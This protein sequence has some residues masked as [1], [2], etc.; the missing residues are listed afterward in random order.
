MFSNPKTPWLGKIIFCLGSGP[1]LN[2]ISAEEWEGLG[3]A[4]ENYGS[5][6]LAVNSSI[7]KPRQFGLES[8][9]LFFTD[10]SWFW[11]NE[12]LVREFKGL[13]FTTSRRAKEDYLDLMRIDNRT[14]DE[15]EVGSGRLKDG[16]SSGHRAVSLSVMLGAKI[17]ILLGYDMRVIEGKSHFHNEYSNTE[18]EKEY[19]QGFVPS[20]DKWYE[21][22]LKVGCQILN[23]TPNSAVKEFPMINLEWILERLRR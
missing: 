10:E 22:A 14:M 3:K 11:D 21:K 5:V 15:F 12:S 19:A 2:L 18:S 7:K 8:D 17:V 6:L 16:R 9:A 23:A 20:F 1:S 4:Q 13:K